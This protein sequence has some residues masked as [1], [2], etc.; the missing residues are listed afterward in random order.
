MVRVLSSKNIDKN[1]EET[2]IEVYGNWDKDIFLLDHRTPDQKP[3]RVWK[4]DPEPSE[5]QE[6]FGF[7]VFS[8]QLNK[9]TPD[10]ETTLPPTDCRFRPDQRAYENGDNTLASSEK[11]RLEEKQRKTRK[12]MKKTGV[13]YTPKYFESVTV[14][15]V[16]KKGTYTDYVPTRD[17]W[18]DK[19]SQ[20]WPDFLDVWS[21][22]PWQPEE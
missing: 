5:N 19:E 9:L 22:T 2:A 16:D 10:M 11:H 18:A 8:L 6:I 14:N 21:D 1:K 4:A 3:K 20:N 17:Y 15:R 7:S 13:K 12:A